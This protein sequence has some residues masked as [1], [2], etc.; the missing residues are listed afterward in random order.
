MGWFARWVRTTF[1]YNPTF[2][3]S[4]LLLLV[5]LRLL[6]RDG[7]LDAASPGGTAGGLS[8]LQGYELG[9]LVVALLVL[10]PRRIAYETTAVL[11]VFGVVRYAAPF[12][13]IGHAAEGG[14]RLAALLG[15]GLTALMA[16]KDHA[17]HSRVGLDLRGWERLHDAAMFGAACVGFPLLAGGL[18]ATGDGLSHGESRALQL[19]LCWTFALLLA[20]LALGLPDLGRD[21]GPLR[22]RRTAAVWRGLSAV[23]LTALLWN[24]LWL[25]GDSPSPYTLL[26]LGLVV[27][28]TFTTIARA[29]GLDPRLAVHLPAL[30]ALAVLVTPPS[31]LFGRTP[32]LTRPQALLLFLPVA[33]A[34]LPLLGRGRWRDG[35]PSFGAVAALAP[36]SAIGTLR[37]G[38]H[39]ALLLLLSAAALGAWR[40]DDGLL[41][42]SAAGAVAVGVHLAWVPR[43]ADAL[44]QVP[45]AAS[46][47]LSLLA[48]WRCPDARAVVGLTLAMVAVP[49]VGELVRGPQLPA[50]GL[51]LV[52]GG[53]LVTLGVRRQERLLVHLGLALPTLGLVRRFGDGVDPGVGLVLLAFAALPVGTVVA[54]RRE[55]RRREEAARD[56][57]AA[58]DVDAPLTTDLELLPEEPAR[59]GA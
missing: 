51:L 41:A 3:L 9:L 34:A 18:T 26:P 49:A 16:L 10:W 56:E 14:H 46:A 45:L 22:S 44:L 39:Y 7:T 32:L 52:A 55:R 17:V 5:G 11:I 25:G 2:P 28:A 33:A 36:L 15:V 29:A 57:A 12:L 47:A 21:D 48:A 19:A 27:A 43:S 6:A 37:D 54:L 13:V 35:L 8:I 31:A 40:R 53:G 58:R 42:W 38:E 30:A 1:D 20:P 4:A 23:G 50:L 24:A 59:V